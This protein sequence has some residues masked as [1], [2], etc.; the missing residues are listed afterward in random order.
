[1]SADTELIGRREANAG[2]A[3]IDCQNGMLGH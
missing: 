2:F 3:V 1:M